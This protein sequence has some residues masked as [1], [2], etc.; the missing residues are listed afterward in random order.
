MSRLL[1]TLQFKLVAG[2]TVVLALALAGVGLSVGYAAQRDAD[3][4]QDDVEKARAA[5]VE[6]LVSSHML[7][8]R[9]PWPPGLQPFLEQAGNLYSW[10]IVVKDANGNIV[11]DSHRLSGRFPSQGGRGYRLFQLKRRGERFGSLQVTYDEPPDMV[12]EPRSTVLASAFNRSLMW[13]GAAAAVMGL[14]L[15]WL[16]SRRVL[17]PVR[18]LSVAAR[19][20]GQGDL[21]QRVD[22]V[23]RDEIG[24]LGRTF[25][26]MATGLEQAERQRRNLM[27]DV[28]HELRTPLSNI[29]GYVEAVRD[30]LMEP[31]EATIASIHQQVLHLADL[32]E[33]LRVLAL[34]EAGDLRLNIEPDSIHELLRRS[35]QS[36]RPRAETRNISIGLEVDPDLPHA[37]MDRTRV[38][39]VVDNLLEN[40]IRHTPDGGHVEIT[41]ELGRPSTARVTVADSGEGIPPD[42]LPNVFDRFYRA[43]PSRAR[44]TGGA[45]L[46]LTIAKQ[47]VEVHGGTMH[48]ESV[49]GEGSRFVF[50]LP[51]AEQNS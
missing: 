48:V 5:R 32:V 19:R 25:N 47:L 15:V 37:M 40:A 17:A 49:P 3:E 12:P 27:S 29:Q 21:A 30:G 13:A 41:A 6:Q 16:V 2:F 7:D 44:A 43:D 36:F 20:L 33:D 4:F 42:D 38:S 10:R 9:Q 46:G 11:A 26:S 31:D 28:A 35:V 45:G 24:E 23:G 39:Q 50:E 51:L 22:T 1:F 34:A 14:F 8:R 18:S